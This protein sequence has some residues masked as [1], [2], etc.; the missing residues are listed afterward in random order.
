MSTYQ[1]ALEAS[2]EYFEGNDLAAKVFCDKYALR[3]ED[4][5]LVEQT[6][7]DMHRRLAKEFARVE[8]AK[9]SEPLKHAQ[10]FK[11]L[12]RFKYI[13]PQG[14]PMYGIGNKSQ[15]VSIANCFVLDPP[16]DSYGGILKV[17]E[18]LVQISKRRGGVGIDV[19]SLRP[20][21]AKTHNS[22]HT[23]T[24]VISFMERYSNSIREVG[25]NGRRGALMLTLSVH[26]PQIVDFCNVKKDL[27]KVTGANISV[28]LTDEF[29]QAVK[30][31]QYYEQRWP[32][33]AKKPKITR[34]VRARAIWDQ[35]VQN[36][37][38]NAE[39]GILFW[40]NIIKE[41][42]ADCY[43]EFQ[44]VSTN[45][46]SE[47]PLSAMDACRLLC[48]NVF[49]YVSSPFTE[50]ASFDWRLFYEHSKL[51]Q[52]L[53]DNI[54]DLEL[55][56]IDRIV[57]KI[58]ADPECQTIKDR[59]LDLWA[60]IRNSCENGRRCGIGI[61]ALGDTLAALGIEYGSDESIEVSEKIYMA[62][63]LG[64]YRG[65]VELAEAL[66]PFPLWDQDK[67]K[68]NP[69]LLRMK[70]DKL[71]DN[72]GELIEDGAEL[73]NA[74]VAHGRRNV[75]LLTIAPTGSVSIET[76]TT[77]GVEPL[78]MMSYTRR[79]KGNPGD[80]DFRVDFTDE[81]GDCWMNFEVVHPK[82]AK[83]MEVTGETDLKK[84]PWYGCCA[85]DLDWLQRVRLQA[86]L[87]KHCDH[88]ISSTINLPEDVDVQTVKDI[89]ETAWESGCKGMTIYRNNCRS[90]VLVSEEKS[91]KSND[92]SIHKTDAIPRPD[93]LPCDVHHISVMGDP[94]FVM[95]G[96]VKGEPY[97]VFAGKNGWLPPNVKTGVIRKMKRPKCYR[98]TLEDDSV[99][100]PVTMSCSESEEALTRM[101][102]TSL[103]HG[104]DI[105]F[106]VEQ[107]FKTQ[108]GMM[109]F[110]KAVARG[111]KKYIPDGRKSTEICSACKS[112]SLAYVEGCVTCQ[113]CGNS[114]CS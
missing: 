31:D 23:S 65:S 27:T 41:S 106:I 76:E 86:A 108:G 3:D 72:D 67:E 61:T 14:S 55:E 21:G 66:G 54:V 107:L 94:Y 36:A 38:D 75:A 59:E 39:P 104:A 4:G 52:R 114:K 90:G 9:F 83:W 2:E 34:Q 74:M 88:A 44:T 89:Y 1:T 10:I 48:L 18:Q 51:A 96:L 103:R 8:R 98:A 47:I 16:D 109:S 102:S 91:E 7:E 17:D 77:S 64:A 42:P 57:D 37:R 33:D 45:P 53:M 105:Q 97:E 99:I 26:H 62:L 71:Y 111:L 11:L 6:P 85:E 46:C 82:I 87:Q 78:F 19:S 13:V 113:N 15:Y 50:E 63:K 49:N 29:L 93:E 73:Y 20:A 22:S 35:I 56:H 84:S 43:E 24:G 80:K 79:K 100:Q 58:K 68:K 60:K 12:D 28:R 81:N 70:K 5:E 110:A 30:D 32:V 112:Q 40:D 95:V 25:Q 69:F 92:G 101:I